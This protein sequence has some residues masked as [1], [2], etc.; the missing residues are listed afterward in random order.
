MR[1]AI[2]AETARAAQEI[3]R[4]AH[5]P[6]LQRQDAEQL[7]RPSNLH[8]AHGLAGRDGAHGAGG[9]GANRDARRRG[10]EGHFC[11]VWWGEVMRSSWC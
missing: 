8:G 3:R 9:R 11:G 6:R 2:S 4:Q 5:S 1:S 7:R 10:E